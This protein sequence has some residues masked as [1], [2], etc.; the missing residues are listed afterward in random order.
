M[1]FVCWE[2]VPIASS[3]SSDSVLVCHW[4]PSV[5]CNQD[6]DGGLITTLI[7][8]LQEELKML[9]RGGVPQERRTQIWKWIVLDTVGKKFVC[10]SCL[11]RNKFVMP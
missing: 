5:L 6:L 1:N 7:I 8:M 3:R 11:P 10:E 4:T 2:C 9:I